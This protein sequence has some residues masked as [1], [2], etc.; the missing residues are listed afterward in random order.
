MPGSNKSLNR[1]RNPSAITTPMANST[2][3][4]TT[5]ICSAASA[6][7]RSLGAHGSVH[8]NGQNRPKNRR[9]HG[10]FRRQPQRV[11]YEFPEP[12]S[13][14]QKLIPRQRRGTEGKARPRAEERGRDHRRK[15]QVQ[16][17]RRPP[18]RPPVPNVDPA[19]GAPA[20]FSHVIAAA[21]GRELRA[22]SAPAESGSA[23]CRT[24]SCGSC[25]T[26]AAPGCPP[27]SA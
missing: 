22:P 7:V 18:P 23:Q 9:D 15:W 13:S 27:S 1:R 4:I 14:E 2:S 25:R 20:G 8:G 24:A 5:G 17:H 3:G 21:S 26:V 19:S 6:A 11:A 12:G 10:R 16:N